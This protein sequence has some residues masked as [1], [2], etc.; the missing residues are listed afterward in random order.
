[1]R[2][3]RASARPEASSASRSAL[4]SHQ[5]L[6]FGP[7]SNSFWRNTQWQVTIGTGGRL[8]SESTADFVGMRT[9]D[10]NDKLEA[11]WSTSS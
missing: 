4:P 2:A 7:D 6:R 9:P 8:R 1:M 10:R 3:H 5:P 11:V